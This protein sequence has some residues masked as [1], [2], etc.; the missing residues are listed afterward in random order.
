MLLPYPHPLE[1]T[2][3]PDSSCNLS[4]THS[5]PEI[6][7]LDR[8][9][10]VG[11][12]RTYFP[13]RESITIAASSDLGDPLPGSRNPGLIRVFEG[14]PPLKQHHTTLKQTIK[15]GLSRNSKTI[16][17]LNSTYPITLSFP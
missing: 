2:A 4:S 1:F 11:L 9:P 13:V 6:P 3:L 17:N 15:L 7:S 5:P 16:A 10:H 12:H 8:D 14:L